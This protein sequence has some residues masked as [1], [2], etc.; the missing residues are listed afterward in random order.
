MALLPSPSAKDPS[1]EPQRCQQH[2]NDSQNHQSHVAELFWP[3]F[4]CAHT[5]ACIVHSGMLLRQMDTG[6]N[7]DTNRIIRPYNPA[8]HTNAAPSVQPKPI[9]SMSPIHAAG[10]NRRRDAGRDARG[11]FYIPNE[12]LVREE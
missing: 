12:T 8:N 11:I 10:D 3:T 5:P 1:D 2:Q 6:W 9:V 4:H 7:T